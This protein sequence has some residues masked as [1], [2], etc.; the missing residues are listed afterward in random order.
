[1][2]HLLTSFLAYFS[3][4]HYTFTGQVAVDFI[5]TLRAVADFIRCV[6]QQA[7]DDMLLNCCCV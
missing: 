3:Y 7:V 2:L 6:G 5:V 4:I 1:M